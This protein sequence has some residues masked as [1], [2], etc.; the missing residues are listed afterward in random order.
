MNDSYIL[1]MMLLSNKEFF[2][3]K[4]NRKFNRACCTCRVIYAIIQMLDTLQISSV[5]IYIYGGCKELGEKN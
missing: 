5:L 2:I 1:I 4:V 3:F